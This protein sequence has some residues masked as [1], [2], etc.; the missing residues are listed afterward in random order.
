MTILAIFKLY[1]LLTNQ[2]AFIKA[3]EGGIYYSYILLL[4]SYYMI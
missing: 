2:T 3:V 1:L 4:F